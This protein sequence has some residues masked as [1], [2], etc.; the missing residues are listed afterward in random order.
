MSLSSSIATV[1]VYLLGEFELTY[2]FHLDFVSVPPFFA[3]VT[4]G[5]GL[6]EGIALTGQVLFQTHNISTLIV[7]PVFFSFPWS[8]SLLFLVSYKCSD[9]SFDI[10]QASYPYAKR[11]AMETF[12][13]A[14]YGKISRN[15]LRRASTILI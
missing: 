14:D 8:C 12:S 15:M 10:F 1:F 5:L 4:R 3:L 9:P 7:C 11:R 6:L 2:L 13:V